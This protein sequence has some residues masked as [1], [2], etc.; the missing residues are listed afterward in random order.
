MMRNSKIYF[1]SSFQICN[2]VLSTI[3]TMLYM[4]SPELI[5]L[6]PRSL[7]LFTPFTHFASPPTSLSSVSVNSVLFCFLD[8]MY[9]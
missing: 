5:Y 1:L 2:T 6:I 7:Y 8:F 9:K 4:T 3:V